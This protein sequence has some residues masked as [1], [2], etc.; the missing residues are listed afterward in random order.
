MRLI[1]Q[2]HVGWRQSLTLYNMWQ[3]SR[4]WGELIPRMLAEIEPPAIAPDCNDPLP[5]APRQKGGV[6][7][8]AVDR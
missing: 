8:Y 5:V 2:G 6:H 4:R 1:G 3:Q 7:R